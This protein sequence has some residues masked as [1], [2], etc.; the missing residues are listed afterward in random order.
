V[1]GR[2]IRPG[3]LCAACTA[4]VLAL[5]VTACGAVTHRQYVTRADGI[6]AATLRAT[7][8][9]TPPQQTG[10]LEQQLR[11]LSAYYGRIAS[12]LRK[13]DRELRALTKPKQTPRQQAELN[14]Y[15]VSLSTVAGY[16]SKLAADAGSG[17]PEQLASLDSALSGEFLGQLARSYGL[18]ECSSSGSTSVTTTGSSSASG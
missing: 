15:L 4:V 16:F 8:S 9:L 7:R 10:T 11:S 12:L 14:R 2:R 17:K 3:V 5:A 18:R 1:R 13:Q 6:C